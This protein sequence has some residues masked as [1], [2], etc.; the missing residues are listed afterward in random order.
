MGD[1]RRKR[2]RKEEREGEREREG[3]RGRERGGRERAGRRE[4]ERKRN[5][6]LSLQAHALYAARCFAFPCESSVVNSVRIWRYTPDRSRFRR[7]DARKEASGRL[8]SPAHGARQLPLAPVIFVLT[9]TARVPEQKIYLRND[10][11]VAASAARPKTRACATM[12]NI[13]LS[14]RNIPRRT[15]KSK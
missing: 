12:I 7:K 2:E 10:G 1:S 8:A 4:R 3:G 14:R 9:W 6:P 13:K 15:E 11:H 5:V